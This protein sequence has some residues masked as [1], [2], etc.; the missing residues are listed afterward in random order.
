MFP[1]GSER[2]KVASPKSASPDPDF[3]KIQEQVTKDK[4]F[5]KSRYGTP[6]PLQLERDAGLL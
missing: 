4:Q 2:V 6:L 3:Q 5:E 1:K